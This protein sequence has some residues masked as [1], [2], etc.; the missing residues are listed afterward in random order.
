MSLRRWSLVAAGVIL[1]AALPLS[2]SMIANDKS[3]GTG[4]PCYGP[5][6]DAGSLDHYSEVVVRSDA[7]Q[8]DA[9]HVWDPLCGPGPDNKGCSPDYEEP[10]CP[11][12]PANGGA[13]GASSG[14]AGGEAG[15]AKVG[16]FVHPVD[17]TRVAQCELAGSGVAGDPCLKMADC[18]PGYACVGS[19]GGDSGSQAGGVCRHYCCSSDDPCASDTFCAGRALLDPNVPADQEVPVCIP[20]TSCELDGPYPCDASANECKCTDG[21]ACTVVRADGTTGCLPPGTGVTDEPCTCATGGVC[22]CAP[23]Y[24]C[25][26]GTQT[27]R[28]LCKTGGEPCSVGICQSSPALPAGFGICTLAVDA[29]S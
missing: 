15:Q 18:A 24:V 8:S 27:C 13:G 28:Q 9:S 12:G 7:T 5:S 23:G 20:K 11:N 1:G 17:S 25:S 4:G 10:T 21:T 19:S 3:S 14:G 26:Y 6:C 16:C 2:C 22:A 29:G